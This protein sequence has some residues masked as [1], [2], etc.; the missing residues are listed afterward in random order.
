MRRVAQLTMPGRTFLV[1]TLCL[2]ECA[3]LGGETAFATKGMGAANLGGLHPCTTWLHLPVIHLVLPTA[4]LVATLAMQGSQAGCGG[5]PSS[6]Q[7][8]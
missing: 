5:W 4:R 1:Y 6:L 7:R 2:P 3:K 8:V